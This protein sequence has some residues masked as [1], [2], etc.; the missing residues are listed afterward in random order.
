MAMSQSENNDAKTCIGKNNSQRQESYL[1]PRHRIAL[2]ES[3]LSNSHNGFAFRHSIKC[4]RVGW[5]S[6]KQFL[7]RFPRYGV[8]RYGHGGVGAKARNVKIGKT[9]AQI[10]LCGQARQAFPIVYITLLI[11]P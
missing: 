7:A 2:I 1:L 10:A 11:I 8:S 3:L 9:K 5:V 4:L 6:A